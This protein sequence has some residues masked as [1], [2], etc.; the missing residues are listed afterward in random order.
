MKKMKK[1]MKKNEKNEEKNLKNEEKNLKN[2]E[3]NAMYR[4]F[5]G[6]PVYI[7]MGNT[8]GKCS[9][10]AQQTYFTLI[11]SPSLVCKSKTFFFTKWP[12]SLLVKVGMVFFR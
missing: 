10:L 5:L 6:H 7:W 1:K 4:F 9:T 2:E 11:R 8:F 12:P 3:K